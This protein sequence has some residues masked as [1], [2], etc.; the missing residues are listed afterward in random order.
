MRPFLSIKALLL[1]AQVFRLSAPSDQSFCVFVLA[2]WRGVQDQTGSQTLN[3][4]LNPKP[5]TL[6]P[7]P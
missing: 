3:P 1:G 6:N 2:A 4:T 5:L 7:K